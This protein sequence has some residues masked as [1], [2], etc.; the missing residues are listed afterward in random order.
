MQLLNN[1]FSITSEPLEGEKQSYGIELH[2]N[3]FIFAAHFPGNPIVPGVCQIQM[4]TELLEKKFAKRL[5]VKEIKNIKYLNV[6]TPNEVTSLNIT[7]QK[8]A[9]EETSLKAVVLYET[10]EKQYAKI[11]LTYVYEMI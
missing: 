10:S 8:L 4:I 2:P 7:F 3:H 1:F 5:Y 6:L 11:S 9:E